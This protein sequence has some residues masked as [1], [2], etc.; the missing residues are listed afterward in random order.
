MR[1]SVQAG[2]Q[3]GLPGPEEDCRTQCC[4]LWSKQVQARLG[5]FYQFPR[6]SGHLVLPLS[7][8]L[9]EHLETLST[10]PEPGDLGASFSLNHSWGHGKIPPLLCDSEVI[11]WRNWLWCSLLSWTFSDPM[12]SLELINMRLGEDMKVWQGHCFPKCGAQRSNVSWGWQ[13]ERKLGITKAGMHS[14]S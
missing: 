1:H 3:G 9:C 10:Q 11:E 12:L 7:Q 14:F 8:R 5:G 4:R 13:E 6:S 2:G